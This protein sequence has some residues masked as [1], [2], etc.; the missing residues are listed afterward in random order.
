MTVL[1]WIA[2]LLCL[3]QSAMFSGLNLA[4]FSLSKLE[5]EIAVKKGNSKAIKVLNF[6]KDSNFT[7]VTILWGNVAV[8]VLLALLADS[9]LVGILA[10]LF[11]TIVITIFAEIIPQAYFSRNALNVAAMLSPM[12]KFYQL[13]FFPIAKLTALVL[14]KW[15]GSE[16][17][18]FFSEKDLRQ[19]IQLH[20]E[21]TDSDIAK[22]EGQGALNFLDIDD[23][24]LTDEG[25]SIALS[26][27][28]E[29]D[30][31]NDKP[32]FPN[33]SPI[34]DDPFL[35]KLYKADRKWA[36][37][38]D[39][40]QE[41]RLVMNT[42]DFIA[43]VL[44]SG[45][46]AVQP[47]AFCHKPIVIREGSQKLG[48]HLTRFNVSIGKTGTEVIDN[49]VILLWNDSPRIISGTD[50]LGRLFRGIGKRTDSGKSETHKIAQK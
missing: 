15:L 31:E 17:I 20:M 2:I 14:D 47:M 5:L 33:I 13:L 29:M 49:D 28:I 35:R 26:S 10:F 50:I 1:T 12:L 3:S 37:L 27:I 39:S 48:E 19:V 32:L 43:E 6:R 11:S 34:P 9:L 16:G 45:D 38:V 41:P 21:S 42:S 44:M 24:P 36:V 22:I 4:I 30:F 46:T 40:V 8:N 7:L 25:E 23:I 18:R